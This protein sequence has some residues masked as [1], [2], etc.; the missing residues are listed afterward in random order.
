MH[1]GKAK[2]SNTIRPKAIPAKPINALTL[3]MLLALPGIA[4]TA[5][6]AEWADTEKQDDPATLGT[7]TV[8]AT[9]ESGAIQARR[10]LVPGGVT[11]VDGLRLQER[12]VNNTADALRYVPGVYVTSE[13]GA[14]D[15]VRLS[16]RGSNLHATNYDNSGV[17]L[18]QDGLPVTTAS[19]DNHNRLIDPLIASDIIVARGANALT[20]GAS[21]LGGAMDFISRTAR[22]SD[23]R[24]VTV[25][26]GND[27]LATARANIGGVSGALDGLLTIEGKHL[28]G[29]RAH[30]EENR[31]SVYANAGWRASDHLDLRF[32][33]AY[34]DARQALPGGLTQAQ[35]D[36]DP[37]QANP[38]Y[39]A[40]NH[41]LDVKTYRLATTG[42][43]EINAK[44]KLEFGLSYEHQTLY[45]PIVTS[46]DYSLLID[47]RQRTLGGML[48]YSLTTGGHNIL[49]GLN[50]ANTTDKGGNY[51]NDAGARG[52]LQDAV[53]THAASANVFLMDR[54][55]LAPRW[56]LIYGAQGVVT[57]LAD[58]TI[59]GVNDGN[60]SPRDR[61]DAYSSVNPRAGVIYALTPQSEAYGNISRLYAAPNGFDLD[62]AR[63]ERGPNASLD[64]MH[65]ISYEAG[66]RGSTAA[67]P[68]APRYHWDVSLYYAKL[69]NEILSVDNP[70][71]PGTFL[72]G[73]A[74]HT[75]HAGIE[76]L[77]SAS[78]PLR[79]GARIEPLVSIT[80]NDFHFDGDPAYGGNR[81]PSVPRYVA[82]GEIMYRHAGGFYA[83]PTFDLAS[84][85]YADYSNTY[86]VSGYGLL[87]ARAGLKRERW[88]LFAEINNL[89][90][91]KYVAS[92][93]VEARASAGDAILNPGAG[94]SVSAGV[95]LWY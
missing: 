78:F 23:P 64:P 66:L 84:D 59:D 21:D 83:G 52:Q 91:K 22:N 18:F 92:T 38:S 65:G 49:A 2:A 53:N 81:L 61:R 73:N 13:A 79:N 9:D 27:G 68:E 47:T 71:K 86:R 77:T 4:S 11:I 32:F 93:S 34:I 31:H 94:R 57:R 95:R 50:L 74:A 7:V 33:G 88:E 67:Q 39:A 58:H 89:L 5:H 19:G 8:H 70:Q 85:R 43:W 80:Y 30:S 42:T 45:H 36:A 76:A 60:R 69:G 63:T 24:E 12:P 26:G 35:F 51:A 1:F 14:S 48:R 62:N 29:Y 37:R 87:G 75:T 56:T 6:S 41:Q 72:T 44:S 25:T 90:D 82:H 15:E 40:G 3:A 55:K 46:P 16:I 10:A 28:D 20:Y 54:W 17:A